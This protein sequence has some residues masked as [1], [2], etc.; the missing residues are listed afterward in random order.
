MSLRISGNLSRKSWA[1]WAN[2]CAAIV[3]CL[4]AFT[5]SDPAANQS[6]LK[7]SRKDPASDTGDKGGVLRA[8]TTVGLV[9]VRNTSDP[10][11]E[12]PRP[13]GSA[14][15][16]RRDGL[17]VTNLHVIARDNSPE[18]YTE[19]FLN[20]PDTGGSAQ[21]AMRRYRLKPVL[22]DNEFDLVLLRI[23]SDAQGHAL[24]QSAALP[25]IEFADSRT[26]QLFDKLIVIGFSQGGGDSVTVNEGVVEGKDIGG[27]WIKTS[28]RLIHGN[29]GGAAVD[30]EGKLIGI[31][32]KVVVDRSLVGKTGG[33]DTAAYDAASVGYLRPA[34]LVQSML[35][36]LDRLS[37]KNSANPTNDQRPAALPSPPP[38][39]LPSPVSVRGVVRTPGDHRPVAG[40]RVGIVPVGVSDITP[41]NLISWGGTNADGLFELNKPVAPGRYSIKVHAIGYQD[42]SADVDIGKDQII[43]ELHV[44]G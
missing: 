2:I 3:C 13:R 19:L 37:S 5:P 31:P 42:Y 36:R 15:I 12:E 41:D 27:Q 23:V 38:S 6:R 29:S 34:R 43:V 44:F 20:L 11:N 4:F 14:V 21:S 25:V 24:P 18:L 7:H 1:Q 17:L 26:V 33:G 9:L 40:A 39:Q 22:I 10:P 35:A 30:R 28:A 8:V 16:V 32:T